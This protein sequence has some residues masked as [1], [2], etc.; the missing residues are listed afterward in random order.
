MTHK[1]AVV[2]N[3]RAATHLETTLP[4]FGILLHKLNLTK[5]TYM[6]NSPYLIGRFLN[7]ADGLHVVWCRNVREKDPLPPQLLGSSLF[8]SFLLNPVQAFGNAGL[9]MKPYLDWAKTNQTSDAKLSHWFLGEFGRVFPTPTKP[10]CFLAI[11]LPLGSRK[12]PNPLKPNPPS[13][14]T[15]P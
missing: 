15:Q 11:L 7:L 10:K 12:N 6:E 14:G 3:R 9:R 5:E 1:R 8:A 4:L 13:K 2:E